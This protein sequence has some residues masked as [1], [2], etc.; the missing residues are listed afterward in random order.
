MK[1][2]KDLFIILSSTLTCLLIVLCFGHSWNHQDK[3]YPELVGKVEF[4]NAKVADGEIGI[5][6]SL[7]MWSLNLTK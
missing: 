5:F 1:Q 6:D 7:R 3:S 4:F 2:T